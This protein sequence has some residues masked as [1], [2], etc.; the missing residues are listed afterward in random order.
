MEVIPPNDSRL[1]W[2]GAVSLEIT[3]EWVKPWRVPHAERFLY[4][5][6]LVERAGMPA[7]VRISFI[8]D[9][10]VV[11]CRVVP[12]NET[13]PLDVCCDEELVATVELA[14]KEESCA[15]GLPEGEKLVELWLPQTGEFKLRSLAVA[16]GA[17]IESYD[18]ERRRWVV[19]GSSIAHCGAAESPTQTWPAVVARL[20]GFDLT[21]LGFGGQCHLDIM[22]GR[23]IR[24]LP[25]DFITLCVGINIYG[26]SSLGPRTFQQSIIGYVKL[27]REK[28]PDIPVVVMS[29]ISSPPDEKRQNAVGFTLET[30]RVEVRTAVHKLRDSGDRGV[31]YVD[32]LEIFGPEY[33]AN[34]PDGVHLDAEGYK[35]FGRSFYERVVE[36]LLS[37]ELLSR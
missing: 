31:L 1:R 8:S 7:G 14:G 13:A 23:L 9:T 26:G 18:E 35:L 12:Q 2:C 22:I 16:E 20:A 11:L 27:I 19:Y 21:C 10:T 17:I 33:E 34:L 4:H 37:G 25:T 24:D 6:T 30:M 28:H 15:E 36:G 3:D 29:P 32:G 5:E